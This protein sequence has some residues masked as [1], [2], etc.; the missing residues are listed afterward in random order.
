MKILEVVPVFSD[1]FGGPV[2]VVRSIS[3][4]LAKRHE[5]VVYTTTALDPKHDLDPHEEE[6]NGYR[7]IYFK[8]TLKQLCYSGLFGQLNLSYGMM[9]AVKKNLREFDVVHIHSWRQFPDV[10]VHH[11]AKKYGIRYILQTH[12]S[13]PRIYTKNELKWLY[14]VF[15]GFRL[16][17][18]ASSVIALS[19]TE[20]WQFRSMGVPEDKIAIVP[21]GIDLTGYDSI[22][23]DGSFKKKAGI[24]SNKKIILYLGRIHRT[25]GI[26]LLVRAF[27]HLIRN[28]NT[29]EYVLVI[30]GPDDGYLTKIKSLVD[31]LGISQSVLFTGFLSNEDKLGALVD[32]CV[33][34]TPS[35]YGFPMTFLEACLLGVPLVTTKF[36]DSLEWI[37][38]ETGFVT[39]PT[40]QDL[41]DAIYRIVADNTLRENLSK[42]CKC[43][44]RSRFSAENIAIKLEQ[45]YS[46]EK[47]S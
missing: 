30:A 36:G 11:Y 18:D 15:F 27:A 1:P 24:G 20:R 26:D 41:S 10:L 37:N 31:L 34:V 43:L 28:K 38:G 14:D 32:A 21:N 13:L 7:V 16:L 35:F 46:H 25:K 33:F 47:F 6:A 17:N 40:V 4:E 3:K 5:V 39:E 22:P 29:A 45:I 19:Q 2:T 42:K 12:G 8:R 23:V 9:Q 44:V